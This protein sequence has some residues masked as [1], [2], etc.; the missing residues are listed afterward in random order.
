MFAPKC[1]TLK[2]AK[3]GDKHTLVLDDIEVRQSRDFESGAPLTH[4]DGSPV[5]EIV[6]RGSVP[7]QDGRYA[8]YLKAQHSGAFKSAVREAGEKIPAVGGVVVG[9]YYGDGEQ[10]KK[11]FAKPKLTRWAYTPPAAAALE[12]EM[13]SGTVE[14]E[15]APK[16]VRAPKELQE[17][18]I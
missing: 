18:D 8:L 14:D 10:A 2:F 9:E 15:P 16:A 3:V 1:T 6:L 4:P 17:V 7:G 13:E 12:A 5:M 11:G